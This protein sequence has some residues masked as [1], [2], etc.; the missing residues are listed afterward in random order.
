MA[1]G[2]MEL[3]PAEF[4]K[5]L[6]GGRTARGTNLLKTERKQQ[7][8]AEVG[9]TQRLVHTRLMCSWP[10][11]NSIG[12]AADRKR[13]LGYFSPRRRAVRWTG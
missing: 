5:T 13:D 6:A 3:S 1:V 4:I 2:R 9:T 8:Q 11:H 12:W 7:Q 10:S